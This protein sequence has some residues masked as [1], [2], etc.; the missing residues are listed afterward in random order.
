MICDRKLF[1]SN[2]VF[3]VA[4]GLRNQYHPYANTSLLIPW[5][6]VQAAQNLYMEWS[7]GVQEYVAPFLSWIWV[8]RK[9]KVHYTHLVR[10]LR[11]VSHDFTMF[12]WQYATYI[13]NT[14]YVKSK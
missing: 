5:E 9:D 11:S 10:F 3:M 6:Q 12:D 4:M 2:A 13:L 8:K 7:P 14:Y 1:V